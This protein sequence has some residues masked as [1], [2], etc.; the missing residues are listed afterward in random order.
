MLCCCRA[1]RNRTHKDS[2][3]SMC[4]EVTSLPIRKMLQDTEGVQAHLRN[5]SRA[6]LWVI[7]VQRAEEEQLLERETRDTVPTKLRPGG[8]A[9]RGCNESKD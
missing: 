1:V 4:A 7:E 2:D 5:Q 9:L 6:M 8:F 3:A